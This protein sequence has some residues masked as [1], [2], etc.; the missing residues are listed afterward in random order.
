[1][2]LQRSEIQSH[3]DICKNSQLKQTFRRAVDK[4]TMSPSQ[5][6]GYYEMNDGMVTFGRASNPEVKAIENS[7]SQSN[8]FKKSNSVKKDN[9]DVNKVAKSQ[10][11]EKNPASN[12]MDKFDNADRES[13]KESVERYYKNY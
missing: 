11:I 13:S 3:S 5:K 2:T 4:E 12:L 7:S 6:N 10:N 8:I 1:M 9:P